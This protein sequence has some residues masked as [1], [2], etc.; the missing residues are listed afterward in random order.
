[1]EVSDLSFFFLWYLLVNSVEVIASFSCCKSMEL[2]GGNV[3]F[4]NV[5]GVLYCRVVNLLQ[6]YKRIIIQQ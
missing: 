2:F 4:C 6:Y 5:A 3:T 1:M